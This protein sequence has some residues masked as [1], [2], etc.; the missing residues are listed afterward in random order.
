MMGTKAQTTLDYGMAMGVFLLAIAF[1]FAM[2][3]T[4]FEPILVTVDDDAV[5]H[6]ERVGDLIDGE[7]TDHSQY[8]ASNA[9]VEAFFSDHGANES[10]LRAFVGLHPRYSLNVTVWN[11]STQMHGVGPGYTGDQ[12]P[13]TAKQIIDIRNTTCNPTCRIEVRIW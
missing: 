9:T 7:V 12:N 1:T 2:A 13:V 8:S 5:A 3:P 11:G 4:F 10:E 6:A